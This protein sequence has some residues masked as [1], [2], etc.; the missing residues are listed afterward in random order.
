[1]RKEMFQFKRQLIEI[2]E[3]TNMTQLLAC[4]FKT[5]EQSSIIQDAVTINQQVVDMLDYQPS[6]QSTVKQ[7]SSKTDKDTRSGL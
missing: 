6:Q 5:D 1:M 3:R 2:N 7:S 4:Y